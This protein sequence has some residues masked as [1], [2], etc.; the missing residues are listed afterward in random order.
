[1]TMRAVHHSRIGN[2][3]TRLPITAPRHNH[4]MRA[5]VLVGCL[6][7]MPA[8]ASAMSASAT[9]PGTRKLWA[10]PD[11]S[12]PARTPGKNYRIQPVL[13][14]N[15][16]GAAIGVPAY[17][18]DVYM[19]GLMGWDT[20]DTA[21]LPALPKS[22]PAAVRPRISLIYSTARGWLAVPRGWRPYR[23]AD[24]VDG[25]SPLLYSAPHGF[26]HGWLSLEVIP[27]CQGCV[28]GE[29]NGFIPA[30]YKLV[31]LKDGYLKV[32]P[33]MHALQPKPLSLRHPTA[34]TAE[35]SYRTPGSPMVI[36]QTVQ[37]IVPKVGYAPSARSIHVA[38]PP[39]DGALARYLA[40]QFLTLTPQAHSCMLGHAAP[41]TARAAPR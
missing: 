29:T 7:L 14:R 21:K 32:D 25:T 6:S 33:P 38:M 35:L 28:W 19:G 41:L 23:V 40:R 26:D 37:M 11:A 9:P 20:V 4:F 22:I 24:G 30:A 39:D 1:M 34:C 18:L 27:A 13:A 36:R 5:W 16:M 31:G 15:A 3:A 12:Y 17:A 2:T 10:G 8:L